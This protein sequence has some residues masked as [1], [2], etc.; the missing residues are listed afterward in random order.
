MKYKSAIKLSLLIVVT[1]LVGVAGGMAFSWKANSDDQRNN[2]LAYTLAFLES[3]YVD[4]LSRD[5]IIELVLPKI[6][7]ELDPHSS[8][9]TAAEFAKANEPLAGQFDGIGVM[10]NML[11][12]TILVTNVISGGPSAK[13]GMLSGDRIITVN[14]T[15]IAGKKM[16]QDKVVSMLRGKRGS[17]VKLGVE[18]DGSSTLTHVTVTRGVIPI[19]SMEAA[20][21]IGDNV[22]Y[23]KFTRFASSTYAEVLQ[24]MQLLGEQ[25]AK[26]FMLDLRGNSGGYLDQAIILT[27]EFL[28]AGKII[29]YT[30]GAHS[31]RT[32]SIATGQGRFTD[33]PLVVL[34]DE[35]SA[36]AAEILAGGLQDNDRG[37]IV[38]RRS[39]GKGLVQEQIPFEDGSAARITVAR[40]YTPLG[41]SI[42]KPYVPGGATDYNLE[43]IRRIEHN[44]L[45]NKDSIHQNTHEKFV[46]KGGKVLY[47]G[48]GIMP[49]VFVP[50]DTMAVSNYFRNLYVKNLI[51]KYATKLTESNRKQINNIKTLKELDEFFAGRN[52]YA[53]FA[54]FAA[55]N[56]VRADNAKDENQNKGMIVA[57][58]KGYV[59]R[60][61]EL[62]DSAFY[63]Y[64]YNFD[65]AIKK[66]LEA[67]YTK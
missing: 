26:R 47:G 51:F 11:T 35:G 22:G 30:K 31:Q 59:G 62:E 36:S 32:E 3:K 39:F 14:D 38:G 58:I 61:T 25:G 45:F 12:D 18:R 28:P 48:G 49:D 33:V 21:I 24:A 67:F 55:A 54:R 20:L 65:D 16:D 17:Q 50:L 64:V 52:V 41:R 15:V 5:S 57:Q 1:L 29:V 27:N 9:L 6:L 4:S 23:I 46:T 13:A 60:N 44:E 66:G 10:F 34:I 53:D 37:V 2:K 8:Y 7:S 19:K 43:V 42:Q 40:Y 63:H 56:G